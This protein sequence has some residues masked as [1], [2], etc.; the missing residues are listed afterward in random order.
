[1]AAPALAQA[2]TDAATAAGS[3]ATVFEK[4]PG[5]LNPPA[6]VVGRPSEVR[7][8]VA[9]LGIDECDLPV[10]CLGPMDGEDDVAAL[11][12]LVRKAITD[13][14][15]GG[16]VQTAYPAIERNWRQVNVAGTDL[17][18]AEVSFVILM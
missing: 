16:A 3:L 14:Q 4:P 2:I 6:I 7:Y 9:A 12:T 18:Q 13:P 10:L 17:L 15:L 1:V 5:T 8:G 11:I